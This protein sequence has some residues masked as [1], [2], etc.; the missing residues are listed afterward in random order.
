[1]YHYNADANRGYD[2]TYWDH[3][4]KYQKEYEKLSAKL[5]PQS[6]KAPTYEGEL[7]R[8]LGNFYYDR[9]NN[10]HCNDKSQEKR[11]V[12]TFLRRRADA[13]VKSIS[14]RMLDKDLDAVVDYVMAHIIRVVGK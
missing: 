11:V 14:Y 9:F 1:M 3:K 10:G 8:C 6:G 2:P 4:G 5:V 12:N 7:L 13:P